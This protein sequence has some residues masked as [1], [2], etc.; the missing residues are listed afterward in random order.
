M[1]EEQQNDILNAFWTE[2]H[3]N[4]YGFKER[5]DAQ[6]TKKLLNKA[7]DDKVKAFSNL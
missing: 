4:K 6:I 2:K 5:F 1:K 3:R 7:G